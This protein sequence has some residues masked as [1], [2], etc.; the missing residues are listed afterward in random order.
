M[1][2]SPDKSSE[3]VTKK[4]RGTGLWIFF[5][6]Y[7]M[8]NGV[9]ESVLLLNAA[10]DCY[11]QVQRVYALV[12]IGL[13]GFRFTTAYGE[14]TD[15]QNLAVIIGFIIFTIRNHLDLRESRTRFNTVLTAL[16]KH[17]FR[18]ENG[19]NLS[20]V[21]SSYKK[22]NTYLSVFVQTSISAFI[23]YIL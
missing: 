7:I 2:L 23:V 6:R 19:V 15:S 8:S 9:S 14:L 17:Q 10:N 16:Q 13:L 11:Y 5:M 3:P 12:C 1:F 4:Q 22:I 21:F 20:Y 18:E